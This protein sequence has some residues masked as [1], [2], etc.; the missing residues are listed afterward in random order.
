MKLSLALTL[1]FLAGCSTEKTE[2][3]QVTLN[4]AAVHSPAFTPTATGTNAAASTAPDLPEESSPVDMASGSNAAASHT[5]ADTSSEEETKKESTVQDGIIVPA[6]YMPYLKEQAPKATELFYAK[7]DLDL[8]GVDEVV[9][10]AGTLGEDKDD[11]TVEVILLLRDYGDRIVQLGGN[12]A[13]SLYRIQKIKL[14]HLQNM[15]QSVLYTAI[16]NDGEMEGFNLYELK[17]NELNM[18][19]GGDS[20]SGSG[21]AVLEDQN[22]DGEYDTA[23]QMRGSYDVFYYPLSRIYSWRN[24]EFELVRV[25]MDLPD[26]PETVQQVIVEFLKLHYLDEGLSPELDKRLAELNR[27]DLSKEPDLL[28]DTWYEATSSQW[29]YDDDAITFHIQEDGDSAVAEALYTVDTVT[30]YGHTFLLKRVNDRWSITSISQ[31]KKLK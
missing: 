5:P 15:K 30:S 27:Y 8:D 3:P 31:Q 10:V 25:K 17:D 19:F 6:R 28:G 29:L 24:H 11:T 9:I 16:T 14:V 26:Y 1:A 4:T 21:V 12:Q 23:I 18:L 13:N 20:A 2:Q 7:E 22:K